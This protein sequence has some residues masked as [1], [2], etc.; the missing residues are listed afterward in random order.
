M[1]LKWDFSA[2]CESSHLQSDSFETISIRSE[3]TCSAIDGSHRDISGKCDT[4]R[5]NEEIT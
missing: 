1:D 3:H 2:A 4:K 5:Y